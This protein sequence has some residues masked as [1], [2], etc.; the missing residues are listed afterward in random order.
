MPIFFNTLLRDAHLLPAEVRL[1]RHKDNRADRGRTPYDL[2][3]DNRPQVDLY[4][5]T[6]AIRNRGKLAAKYWAVFLGTPADETLFVGLYG[7]KHL[8][9]LKK[10]QEAPHIKGDVD[11][12]GTCDVYDLSPQ[13]ALSD[14]IEKLLVDWGCQ[15][16]VHRAGGAVGEWLRGIVP[17]SV[18]R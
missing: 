17:Q 4:Q 10:D 1:V 8:G 11:K 12:A 7:V 2:W 6:Q 5:S 14:F 18:A 13:K 3:R 16:V 15:D 9:L